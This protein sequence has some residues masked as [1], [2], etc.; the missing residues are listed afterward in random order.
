MMAPEK[1]SV[2]FNENFEMQDSIIP[3]NPPRQE[4]WKKKKK[5]KKKRKSSFR[6]GDVHPQ[7]GPTNPLTDDTASHQN[8]GD[9]SGQF[10]P[11]TH[12]L[13]PNETP[14]KTKHRRGRHKL[15]PL[16]HTPQSEFE[17]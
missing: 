12:T 11:M 3:S 2:R 16:I 17:S 8:G 13:P 6:S 10:P 9:N 14:F 4:Q 7:N 5:K 1:K 15:P